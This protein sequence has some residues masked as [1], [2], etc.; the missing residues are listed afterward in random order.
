MMRTDKKT[1]GGAL[2]KA[3]TN[4]PSA[5]PAKGEA[6]KIKAEKSKVMTMKQWEASA[7]DAAMDRKVAKKQGI[8]VAKYE[9]SKL[10]DR[11]DRKQLAAHNRAAKKGGK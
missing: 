10:D 8:P 5:K 4:V 6:A 2:V 3:K 1:S 7:T 9:G 11:N